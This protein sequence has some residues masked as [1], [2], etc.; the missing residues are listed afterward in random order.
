[1]GSR[2]KIKVEKIKETVFQGYDKDFKII[3]RQFKHSYKGYSSYEVLSILK[4]GGKIIGI[5]QSYVTNNR[6]KS[7]NYFSELEKKY[8]ESR[9][10]RKIF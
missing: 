4:Y 1:M 2:E 5:V 10:T 8:P 9:L 7:D 6:V 3:I